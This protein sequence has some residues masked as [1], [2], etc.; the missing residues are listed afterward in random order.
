M[1]RIVPWIRIFHNVHLFRVPRSWTSRIQMKSSMTFIR[2]NRCIER[3]K[4]TFKTREVKRLKECALPLRLIMQ[5][6]FVFGL[7][8]SCPLRLVTMSRSKA[9]QRDRGLCRSKSV[10]QRLIDPDV[11]LFYVFINK[12]DIKNVPIIYTLSFWFMIIYVNSCTLWN[13]EVVFLFD[14]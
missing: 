8:L 7:Q 1:V 6:Y 12:S 2:G 3:E 5:R 11:L 10:C 9:N 13:W 14:T 4:D